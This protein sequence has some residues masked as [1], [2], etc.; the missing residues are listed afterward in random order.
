MEKREAYKAIILFGS[1]SLAGDIIYEGARGITPSFLQFLGASAFIVGLTFGLSEFINFAL[2]LIS[3][4]LADKTRAYWILYAIGY[5]LIISIPLI[6]FTRIL[7]LAITLILI[8]RTAKAFRSPARDTLLSVVSEKIGAGKTFGLHELMDQVG[9]VTGPAFLGIILLVTNNYTLAFSSLFIPY[10]A[11]LILV[12]NIFSK[13]R[14]KTEEIIEISISNTMSL[15]KIITGLP[16]NF[17][18]YTVATTLNAIGL[19]HWS[20]ILYRTTLITAAWIATFLYVLIQLTDAISAPLSGYLYDKYGKNVLIF[21]FILSIITT[22]LTLF[23]TWENL[24]FAGIFYGIVYGMQESIYRAGVSDLVPLDRRGTAYGIFNSF[25]GLG[26]LLSG[27]IFGLIIQL[28]ML[29]IGIIYTTIIQV[30]ALYFL[31]I[32]KR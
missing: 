28:N 25:Y 10:I 22:I 24:I 11:L 2:R 5:L 21:P 26:F 20:L 31:I 9:A 16:S 29:Y 12:V 1:V 15:K 14:S 6:G 4:I 27:T 18:I 3:G 23:G 30:I 13:L 17:K 32:T 7:W 8:E 19:I